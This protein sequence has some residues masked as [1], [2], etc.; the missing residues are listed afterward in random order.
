MTQRPA[1]LAALLLAFVFATA[2]THANDD[3]GIDTASIYRSASAAS[4]EILVGGRLDGSGWF[5]DGEGHIVTAAHAVWQRKEPIE[6][7][8]PT[9]G[10]VSAKVI[11][12]DRGHDIALLKA[13]ERDKPYPH[14][15][16]AEHMPAPGQP[17][18]LFGSALFR[19]QI[20]LR[21]S[22][23]RA[24]PTFEY[25]A[26]QRH[27]VRVYHIGAPSPKGTSGGCW[28]DRRGHVIGNQSAFMSR[29][30]HGTGIAMTA[31]PDAVARLVRTKKSANT[32]SLGT[33]FEETVTQPVG[34]LK[35][36]PKGT[37]GLVPVLAVKKG[38]ADR[39]GLK[40]DMIVTHIDDKP[41]TYRDDAL[42][43][44]RSKAPGDDVTLSIL[45]PDGAEPRQVTVTLIALEH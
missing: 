15:R 43:H 37:T 39:A 14:L 3:G 11:A 4:V 25:L 19:H 26:D 2:T 40:G 24:E 35:R 21:G 20:M 12:F 6:V 30:G 18:F 10:R 38:P 42:R 36:F 31:A 9:I 27:F 33:A 32:P 17:A 29:D 1:A 22:V 7:M 45:P 8:S 41:I 44:I 13:P 34:F 5:A 23:A 28:L 16:V